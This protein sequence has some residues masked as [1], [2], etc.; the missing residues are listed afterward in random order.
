MPEE[1]FY[2]VNLWLIL[3]ASIGFFL[4]ATEAGFLLGRRSQETIGDHSLAQIYT[5]QGATLGLLALL[6]G[7]TFSMAVSRYDARKQ[8]VLEE[9]NAIGTTFLRAQLLP[10]PPREEVSNLL[11]RYVEVRLEFYEAGNNQKILREVKDK[12]ERL[13]NQLWTDGAAL[14][15]K[16]PRAVTTGLFLQSLNEM[17]DLNAKRISALENHVPVVTLVLLYFVAIMATG[18]IG[19]GCGLSGVRKFFV[20]IILSILISAVIMVIIDL[21][22]P[23]MGLIRV[24]QQRML[25]LRDSLSKY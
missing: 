24:N 7:F 12:T 23:S 25:D 22:R 17:I 9:S 10:E 6:L 2:D 21:N 19:Y 14:G 4:L 8:V 11:R 5:I 20:T 18:L 3:V 13:Q 16:D 15:E 1:L